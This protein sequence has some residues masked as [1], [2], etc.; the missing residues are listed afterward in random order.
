MEPT[1]ANQ[2]I[3]I[4]G[5]LDA[6]MVCY[7]HRETHEYV[8]FPNPQQFPDTADWQDDIDT[9]TNNPDDYMAIEPMS[10]RESFALMEQFVNEL[11]AGSAQERLRYTLTQPKPFRRFKD[12]V[13]SMGDYRQQ[14]F[15]FRD[16]KTV[17]WLRDQLRNRL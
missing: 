4:A 2:L 7:L 3:E 17:E 5:E 14:W 15:T 9:V 1:L 16:A 12:T 6:G 11:P 13:D 10:S 8:S